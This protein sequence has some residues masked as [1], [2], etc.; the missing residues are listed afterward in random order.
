MLRLRILKSS[1]ERGAE[2]ERVVKDYYQKKEYQVWKTSRKLS[3]RFQKLR[4]PLLDATGRPSLLA[5]RYGE[6]TFIEARTANRGLSVKQVEWI[7]K[8]SEHDIDVVFLK[9]GGEPRELW[10]YNKPPSVRHL[11]EKV[12]LRPMKKTVIEFPE[13]SIVRKLVLAEP[14]EIERWVAV[15]Q[16]L[17]WSKLLRMEHEGKLRR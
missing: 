14:D 10:F 5:R 15:G 1:G 17:A 8:H 4:S 16:G 13:N 3:H 2:A 9:E 6:F 11:F 12:D 7:S